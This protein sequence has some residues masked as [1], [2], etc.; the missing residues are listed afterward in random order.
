MSGPKVVRVVTREEKEAACRLE[1][2]VFDQAATDLMK[3]AARFQADPV[4]LEGAIEIKRARL[5][6]LL[7]AGRWAEVRTQARREER[8]LVSEVERIQ[9]HA[10]T[11]AEDARRKRRN[12]S[13]GAR[14]V[15][16]AMEAVDCVVPPDLREIPAK[17]MTA[18]DSDIASMQAA[19]NRGVDAL[20]A[21][22]AVKRAGITN[23]LADRLNIGQSGTIT[24]WTTT[25]AE[26]D[27]MDTRLDRL[28]ARV[29]VLADQD[30]I[31]EFSERVKA[32]SESPERRSLLIDS[33]VLD[34]SSYLAGL[35]LREATVLSLRRARLSLEGDAPDTVSLRMRLD[36][37]MANPESAQCASL[38]EAVR[39]LTSRQANAA[40]AAGRRRA[41]L[42]GLA[43]LGYEVRETMATAWAES[44]R[45]VVKKGGVRDYGVEIG[46]TPD[47]SCLQVRVVGAAQPTTPRSPER[48]KG[49]EA[50]WCSD[51]SQL[52]EML[53]EGGH[54]LE[55]QRAL[56]VGDQP[57]KT[58]SMEE[59]EHARLIDAVRPLAQHKRS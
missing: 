51:F 53:S 27:E 34:L 10:I 20:R 25:P 45:I 8:F 39:E 32:V 11:V 40:L 19:I 5:H 14:S 7:A 33:I 43:A 49:M 56:A 30:A 41:V 15:I 57:V 58:V 50:D 46:A 2:A 1:I 21:K 44:G 36:K 13:D 23:K 3:A 29:Q 38:V 26:I 35:A 37:A 9:A 48:D 6:A 59:I 24:Q 54:A 28:L 12:L 22:E 52:G 17:A 47:A 4:D 42:D 31:A 55:I 18:S 16:A